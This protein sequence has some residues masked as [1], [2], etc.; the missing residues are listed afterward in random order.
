MLNQQFIMGLQRN[1]VVEAIKS[2]NLCAM[3]H[4]AEKH[5]DLD[6][7]EWIHPS[8]LSAKANSEDNPTWDQAMNC[9]DREGYWQAMEKELETLQNEKHAWDII[10][11]EHWLN[12]LPSTWSFKC[13]RYLDGTIRKSKARVCARGQ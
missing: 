2:N 7:V 6:T 12:V 3:M 4:I 10:V 13:K 5:T 11:R 9:P 1:H 8:L